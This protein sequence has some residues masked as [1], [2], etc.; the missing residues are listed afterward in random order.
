MPPDWSMNKWQKPKNQTGV[1]FLQALGFSKAKLKYPSM[2]AQTPLPSAR[3]QHAFSVQDKAFGGHNPPTPKQVGSLQKY[4]RRLLVG[5]HWG[6]QFTALNNIIIAESNWNPK[7][8]NPGSGAL[9]IAQALGHGHGSATQGTLGNEY[10]GYGLTDKEAKQ[11][12]SGNGYWQLVWMMDYIKQQYGSPANA[13]AFH[14][15]HGWY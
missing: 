6:N 7:V 3:Y 11:A 1:T 13:W 14:K 5:M 15:S 12:N 2:T 4:A 10:G 8:Q 9:G